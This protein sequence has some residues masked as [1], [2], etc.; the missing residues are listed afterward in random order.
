M[1]CFNCNNFSLF[2]FCSKCK[3][4]LLD[5]KIKRIVLKNQLIVYSFYEYSKIKKLL[6]HKHYLS[7]YFL[8]HNL[9]KFTFKRF[10]FALQEKANIIA[11]DDDITSGYSHTSILAKYLQNKNAKVL[12]SAIL[13]KNNISYKGKSK[14]YRKINKKGFY[15]A[16][17]PKYPVILVDDILT[18]GS[19]LM[20]AYKMLK[21][22][23]IRVLFA[24]VLADVKD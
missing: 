20:Q 17:K 14:S 3:K 5:F 12:Y 8:L 18:T 13:K 4:E 24:V 16:K 23:K 2:T 1:L 19:T 6:W 9:A 10:D 22:E 11:V 15:L 7:G 21:K